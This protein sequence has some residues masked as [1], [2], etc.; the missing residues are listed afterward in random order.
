MAHSDLLETPTENSD[1]T[2]FVGGSFLKAETGGYQAEYTI[3]NLFCPLEYSPL[4][5][6]KSTQMA[7]LLHL[8]ELLQ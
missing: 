6:I 2:V 8:L 5:V 7:N 3:T 1:L 4:P